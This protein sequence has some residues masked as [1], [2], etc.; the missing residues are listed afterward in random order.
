MMSTEQQRLSLKLVRVIDNT[1]SAKGCQA[2][3]MLFNEVLD[4]SFGPLL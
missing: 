2:L 4:I 3:E 1:S